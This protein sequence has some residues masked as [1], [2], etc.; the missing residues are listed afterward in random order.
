MADIHLRGYF[1]EAI[2]GS[3]PLQFNG[4]TIPEF[5]KC[6]FYI[7]ENDGVKVTDQNFKTFKTWSLELTLKATSSKTVEIISM[8]AH[9]AKRYSG[10]TVTFSSKPVEPNLSVGT[11][12][13]RHFNQIQSN[14]AKFLSF[15][16]TCVLQTVSYKK[17][18]SGGHTWTQGDLI[19]ISENELQETAKQVLDKAYRKIDGSFYQEFA[20]RYKTLI[21]E[22][23]RYPIKAL[24]AFY[25]PYKSLKHVQS[26]ATEARKRGLIAKADDGKNSPVRNTRKKGR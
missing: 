22:G 2:A 7:L 15:S 1:A 18:K 6:T 16:V 24:Q 4:R 10:H 12:S 8:S 17:S 9:G 11:I 21:L 3:K 19:E 26:Y 25:Y 13:A 5:F 23:E 14:R 20:E